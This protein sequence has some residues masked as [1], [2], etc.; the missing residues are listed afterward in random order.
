MWKGAGGN[1]GSR[2]VR[3]LKVEGVLGGEGRRGRVVKRDGKMEGL[4]RLFWDGIREGLSWL[5][6]I[7]SV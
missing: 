2:R 6:F 5:F 4:S 1:R 7:L 3:E